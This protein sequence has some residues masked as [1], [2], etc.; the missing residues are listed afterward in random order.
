[1][2]RVLTRDLMVGSKEIYRGETS[3]ICQLQNGDIL[4]LFTPLYRFVLNCSRINLNAK[5]GEVDKR[6]HRPEIVVPKSVAQSALGEVEGY[7][8]DKI[9]GV[10]LMK[11]IISIAKSGVR[12]LN[13]ITIL[14]KKIEEAVKASSNIVFPDLCTISNILITNNGDVKLID[15]DGLQINNHKAVSVSSN[16]T[17]DN[18]IGIDKL[19]TRESKYFKNGLFTKELDKKSLMYLYLY[20]V[21]GTWFSAFLENGMSMPEKML[22][23]A[24]AI[25]V[26]GL[27]DEKE[28]LEKL[29]VMVF[30]ERYEDSYLDDTVFHIADKYD[31]EKIPGFPVK[32]G[33]PMI[34]RL[35]KK[36]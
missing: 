8:M 9:D 3:V 18:P 14:Y 24:E 2:K 15:Y 16:L 36:R 22:A 30:S 20:L 17:G 32:P 26:L 23:R 13:E 34:N 4:K 27:R 10:G 25:N 7:T 29:D 5:I 11:Y 31:L 1:M 35:V 12:D 6:F 28:L 19:T 21:F 33:L